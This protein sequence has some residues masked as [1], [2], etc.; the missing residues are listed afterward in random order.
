MLIGVVFFRWAFALQSD[1]PVRIAHTRTPRWDP[2]D[3]DLTY[4]AVQ[5]AFDAAGAAPAELDTSA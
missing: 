2:S 4:D 1:D 5:A 3:D